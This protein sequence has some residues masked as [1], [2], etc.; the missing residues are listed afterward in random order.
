MFTWFE[1]DCISHHRTAQHD[2]TE[3]HITLQLKT[4]T[5]FGPI[6]FV[7]FYQ[8]YSRFKRVFVLNV[9]RFARNLAYS[10]IWLGFIRRVWYL[11]LPIL[12]FIQSFAIY[13]L[14]TLFIVFQQNYWKVIAFEMRNYQT[15]YSKQWK[16]QKKSSRGLCWCWYSAEKQRNCPISF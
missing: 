16:C 1:S 15:L 13:N 6:L 8:T 11:V 14:M 4:G 5:V 9:N 10:T 2:I 12:T 3:L 7:E